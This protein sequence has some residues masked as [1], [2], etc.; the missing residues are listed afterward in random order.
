MLGKDRVLD[1]FPAVMGSEDFQQVMN[2][3]KAPYVFPF[4]GVAD[5]QRFAEAQKEG[6]LVPYANHNPDYVIDL[7]AI[8]LGAKVNSVM[9][10][11]LFA[12]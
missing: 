8:P 9:A 5:P 11:S 12:Q 10:S 4:I 6:K 7:A 2:V 1:N 3:A